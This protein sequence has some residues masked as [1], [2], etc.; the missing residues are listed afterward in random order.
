MSKGRKSSQ[1]KRVKV[2]KAEKRDPAPQN[3]EST[4]Y[5]L[6]RMNSE[7]ELRR[8]FLFALFA[9]VIVD[10]VMR[11]TTSIFER[12]T[13]ATED[14]VSSL[15]GRLDG[16]R[17]DLLEHL[18]FRTEKQTALI[19]PTH[20]PDLRPTVAVRDSV[21][22]YPGDFE[23]FRAIRNLFPTAKAAS[24]DDLVVD[25]S[26]ALVCVGSQ[27]SNVVSKKVLGDPSRRH[28]SVSWHGKNIRLAYAMQVLPSTQIARWQDDEVLVTKNYGIFRSGYS[29]PLVPQTVRSEQKDDYLLVTRVPGP[30]G[31]SVTIFGGVHGSGTRALSLLMSD[32]IEIGDLRYLA[33]AINSEQYF[34]AVFH[35]T[36]LEPRGDTTVPT[37]IALIR[38]E[39]PPVPL[40][41]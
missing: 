41:L 26:Q 6:P 24:D 23:A 37:S 13:R 29:T 33:K 20:H 35:V 40:I 25:S 17:L 8:D 2:E 12:E 1:H 22:T 7:G 38:R 27:I 18:F 36:G 39:F 10:P 34:Q 3:V 21:K 15:R 4:R 19:V 9:A 5:R 14:L 28:F 32:K 11:I 30:D 31:G 16:A